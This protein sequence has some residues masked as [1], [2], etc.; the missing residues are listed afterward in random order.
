MA[1]AW[2]ASWGTSWAA[3]WA[4]LRDSTITDTDILRKPVNVVMAGDVPIKGSGVE[5][6]KRPVNFR[7]RVAASASPARRL[8]GDKPSFTVR[9]DKRGYD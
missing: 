1:G 7:S 6:D 3:H 8:S 9:T 2:G 5:Y 4:A